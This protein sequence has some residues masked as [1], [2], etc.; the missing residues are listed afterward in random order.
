MKPTMHKHAISGALIGAWLSALSGCAPPTPGPG[1]G[2]HVFA[3]LDASASWRPGLA[4]T[5]SLCAQQAGELN[6][7]ADQLTLYRLD[8]RLQEF[9]SGPAP[10]DP[11]TIQQTLNTQLLA[12]SPGRGTFPA[13]FWTTVANRA[14]TDHCPAVIELF[15]DG[16]NDD[17][18]AQSKHA[19]CG[20]VRKLAANPRVRSVCLFGVQPRNWAYWRDCLRPLGD[21][22]HLF[23]PTELSSDIVTHA[24]EQA[25]P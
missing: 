5:A 8:D 15:S 6:P 3:A 13:R 19:I 9:S 23:S 25:R 18:T 22:A 11:D 12:V 4:A 21:R 1:T 20:A 10:D 7:A 17:Q 2:L 24:L 14:Q 16:D